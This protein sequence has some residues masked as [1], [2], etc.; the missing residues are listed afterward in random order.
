MPWFHLHPSCTEAKD[1][2]QSRT[3][4][5]LLWTFIFKDSARRTARR[6]LMGMQPGAGFRIYGMRN[7]VYCRY[8]DVGFWRQ[9]NSSTVHTLTFC[10]CAPKRPRDWR[11]GM[12]WSDLAAPFLP[13]QMCKCTKMPYW[14]TQTDS[15]LTIFPPRPGPFRA[16]TSRHWGVATNEAEVEVVM[17][18]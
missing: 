13:S 8:A 16:P 10:A 9:V 17:R 4:S 1:T 12:T 15:G 18:G 11:A 5:W 6:R 3:F 14:K 2:R 7:F